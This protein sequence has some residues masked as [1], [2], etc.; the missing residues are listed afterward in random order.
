[1]TRYSSVWPEILCCS[2]YPQTHAKLIDV[3]IHHYQEIQKY[4]QQ[5]QKVATNF[6]FKIN[7]HTIAIADSYNTTK[8]KCI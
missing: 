5:S 3:L 2:S 4:T 7:L 1:M 8:V 6:A